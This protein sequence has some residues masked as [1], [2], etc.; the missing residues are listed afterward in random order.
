MGF[1]EE[2]LVKK[3]KSQIVNLIGREFDD[4]EDFDAL[5]CLFGTVAMA[6]RSR[7]LLWH[8]EAT[9]CNGEEMRSIVMASRSDEFSGNGLV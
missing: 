1:I 9:F 4:D 5:H 2:R 8:R 7:E 6:I 3:L